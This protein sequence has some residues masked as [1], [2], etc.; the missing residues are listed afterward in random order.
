MHAIFFTNFGGVEKTGGFAQTI[1]VSGN[2][3]SRWP[4]VKSFLHLG[5]LID[6]T[7]DPWFAYRQVMMQ[8]G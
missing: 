3:Q 2:P 7:W 5:E 1:S 8:F 6:T 4:L